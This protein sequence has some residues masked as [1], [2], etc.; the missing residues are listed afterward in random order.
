M[1][2]RAKC[3]QVRDKGQLLLAL[4]KELEGNAHISIEGD[5]RALRLATYPGASTDPTD[6]LKPIRFGTDFVVLPLEHS[7]SEKIYAALG[8]RV[9][10]NIVHVQIEKNGV[11]QFGA[12]DHFHPECIA[13]GS[14][15]SQTVVESLVS[16]GVIRPQIEK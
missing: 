15:V 6:V 11:I 5:L 1:N 2:I 16:N 3:W 8:G 9:P 12:Y 7:T 13:F 10:K 14:A 4:M